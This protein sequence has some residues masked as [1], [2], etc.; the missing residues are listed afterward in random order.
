VRLAV[1]VC[2]LN[3]AQHLPK[4]LHSI[5]RQERLPDELLLVDDGSTDESARLAQDF[6]ARREWVR[7]LQRPKR[8]TERDRLGTAA[9]LR[10]F[11]WGVEQL[12]ETP[13][14]VVKMDGDLELSADLMAAAMRKF[15]NE[16]ALG[17]TGAFL[18]H[19]LGDGEPERD[20]HPVLHVRGA[21]KFYRWECYEQIQPIE[22]ILGW[23]TADELAARMHGWQTESFEVPGGDP[24]HLRP[25][26]LHDG[27]LRAYRRWGW[28]AWGYG[29]HPLWVVLGGIS[30]FRAR[31]RVL[32]G[33]SY[34]LGWA[35]A[36]IRRRPR[37]RREVRRQARAEEMRALRS[38]VRRGVSCGDASPQP[39]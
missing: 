29:A 14:V 39:R 7:A 28:C 12:S 25:T 6:A 27:R 21:N 13:G 37:V 18:S 19:R 10:A 2:F 1:I 26:G 35:I 32:A 24:V 4:L 15:E 38:G 11:Q 17:I 22:P 34:I 36:G 8:P 3:E 23:D 20:P 31:P 33:L 9:E 16:P 5:E 30:R